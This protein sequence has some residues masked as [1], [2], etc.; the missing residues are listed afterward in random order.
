MPSVGIAGAGVFNPHLMS[1]TPLVALVYLSWGSD[2]THTDRKKMS[3]I[4]NFLVNTWVFKAQNAPISVF[5]RGSASDPA[6]GELTTPLPI[7]LP[8]M[9]SVS[10]SRRLRRLASDL[11]PALF[12]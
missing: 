12:G 11:P 7:P 6:A 10:R 2:K 3:K 4:L 1:S 8:S 5:G 9:P